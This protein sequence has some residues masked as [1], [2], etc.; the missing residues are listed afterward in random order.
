MAECDFDLL[1]RAGRI[2]CTQTGLD[3][4]GAVAIRGDRIVASGGEVDGTAKRLLEFPEAL[5]LPGLVDLHA[6]PAKSGSKYG[7]DPDIEFLP[8][9]VTT[10]LSQGDVGAENWTAYRNET[11]EGSRTR[12]RLAIN[13]SKMGE[14]EGGLCFREIDWVDV[15]AC[16]RTIREGGDFIWGIAVNVSRNSCALDPRLV[17]RHGLDVAERTGKPLLYGMHDPPNWP[18]AEQ[19]A[20][21]RPGDVVT[22]IFRDDEWSI[23]GDDGR[24]LP[25]VREAGERGVLFDACHGMNSFS[26]HVA[27]AAIADGFYP[28]T[29]STDQYAIH[30]GS[31]PQHDLPRTMSKFLAAGMPE[32]EVFSRV[33]ARPAEILQLSREIGTLAPGSCAD[34]T[35]LTNNCS[36][37]PLVDTRD[38]RR[39]GGCLEATLVVRAGKIVS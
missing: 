34:V 23:V 20:L 3:G 21:L 24:V 11:I 14:P 10:A 17:L 33:G 36:A 16:A 2:V 8:R 9:G 35:L 28:D 31:Q 12:V 37:A 30:V 6:H 39:P 19:L 26:F 13:L 25:E 1:I 7:V 22:Y 32:H 15:D 18:I 5:L 27:E 29:I 38:V 4:P